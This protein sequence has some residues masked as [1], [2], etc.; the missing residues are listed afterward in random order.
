MERILKTG[1]KARLVRNGHTHSSEPTTVGGLRSV[2]PVEFSLEA[3]LDRARTP[4]SCARPS[5]LSNVCVIPK[6]VTTAITLRRPPHGHCSTSS[7]NTRRRRSA[8]GSRLD[9]GEPDAAVVQ[10]AGSASS[11]GGTSARSL[12]RCLLAGPKIPL[13]RTRCRR[14]GGMIPHKRRRNAT[15]SST[16]SVRPSGHGRFSRY[17]MRPSSVH[18]SRSCAIDAV[19]RDSLELQSATATMVSQS[20]LERGWLDCGIDLTISGM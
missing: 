14:G 15:G 2:V 17:A 9:R 5:A 7:A 6:S 4:G 1:P 11:R 12:P 16:S 20:Q 13:Y 18:A 10:R 8:H 3:E 19:S